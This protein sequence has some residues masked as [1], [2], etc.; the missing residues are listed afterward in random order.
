MITTVQS[1]THKKS[2]PNRFPES[3]GANVA[4]KI[5]VCTPPLLRHKE[6]IGWATPL[7]RSSLQSEPL[8]SGNRPIEQKPGTICDEAD[9]A[10]CTGCSMNA[11]AQVLLSYQNRIREIKAI[12]IN[13]HMK[14]IEN[15]ERTKK[16]QASQTVFSKK[17]VHK[18]R[19]ECSFVKHNQDY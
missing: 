11:R 8:E 1:A 12:K 7:P 2:I 10:K 6:P 18:K 3:A 14:S 15:K 13:S 17:R 16:P 5:A 9:I 4:K 19:K